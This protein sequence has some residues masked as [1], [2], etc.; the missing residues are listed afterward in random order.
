MARPLARCRRASLQADQPGCAAR[1]RAGPRRKPFNAVTRCGQRFMSGGRFATLRSI[2]LFPFIPLVLVN[3][4]LKLVISLWTMLFLGPPLAL[5]WRTR[6][7]LAD[8]SAVQLTRN[9][10]ALARGLTKIGAAD[11]IP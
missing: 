9:P 4:L 3:V 11:A 1:D 2:L 7:Y 10:G 5:L 6:R 8:G